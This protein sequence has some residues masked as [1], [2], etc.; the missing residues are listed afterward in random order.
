[1][2]KVIS[3][4]AMVVEVWRW[5]DRDGQKGANEFRDWVNGL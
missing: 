2:E 5:S 4:I 1:L 3:H